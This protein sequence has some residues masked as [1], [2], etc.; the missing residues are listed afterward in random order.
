[1]GVYFRTQQ[2]RATLRNDEM[3]VDDMTAAVVGS[4]V[5]VGYDEPWRKVSPED[6]LA[7]ATFYVN[8]RY[9]I[10]W[11]ETPPVE[12]AST[13]VGPPWTAAGATYYSGRGFD[14]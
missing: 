14:S 2:G 1:M 3:T 4:G 9:I 5:V 6:P 11:W 13:T 8:A 7:Q 10:E 12:Q